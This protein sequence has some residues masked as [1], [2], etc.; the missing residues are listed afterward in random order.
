MS[1]EKGIYYRMDPVGSR[2][3]NLIANPIKVRE[4]CRQLKSEFE[5]D[6]QQC[7]DDVIGFLNDLNAYHLVNIAGIEEAG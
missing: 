5:V 6:Q 7:E 1:I 3:W 2:T 4:L